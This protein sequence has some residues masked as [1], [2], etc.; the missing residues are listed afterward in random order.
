MEQIARNKNIEIS[1]VPVAEGERLEMII[2]KLAQKFNVNSNAADVDVM[3]RLPARSG[4]PKI[5]VQFKT[6]QARD[7]WVSARKQA[8]VK[9][10]EIVAV[11]GPP[12]PVYINEQLTPFMKDLLWKTK[13]D[14]KQKGYHMVWFKNNKILVKKNLLDKTVIR[15]TSVKD[16][17]KIVPIQN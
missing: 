5:V 4:I 1:G 7:R 8:E 14:A 17:S 11:S 6:R 12:V 15:I 3:H 16:L 2:N 9:S 10:S 13:Q